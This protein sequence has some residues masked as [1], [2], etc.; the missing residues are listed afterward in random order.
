MPPPGTGRMKTPA[1]LAD[2]IRGP[3]LL[4]GNTSVARFDK[5]PFHPQ[6]K[7]DHMAA[8]LVA[9]PGAPIRGRAAAAAVVHRRCWRMD[10]WPPDCQAVR[11]AYALRELEV[12]ACAG[13]Y[14]APP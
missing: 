10:P 9:D 4:L 11:E 5:A 13:A 8:A 6:S 14:G 1:P 3:R 2:G 12:R 7:T